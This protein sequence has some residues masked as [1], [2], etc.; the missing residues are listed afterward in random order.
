MK[1][2]V[3]FLTLIAGLADPDRVA[4]DK[5]YQ[6]LVEKAM[7]A[8]EKLKREFKPRLVESAIVEHKKRDRYDDLCRG[9]K[10]DFHFKQGSEGLIPGEI[11][12]KWEEAG[13]CTILADEKKV[14]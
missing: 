9:F 4:L 10:Q 2:R 8:A 14:A 11:A 5:K 3:K 7:A 1:K 6:G 13:I 12:V